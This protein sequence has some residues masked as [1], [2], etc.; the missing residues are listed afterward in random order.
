M[1][2]IYLF[3]KDIFFYILKEIIFWENDMKKGVIWKGDI[4]EFF[5][6]KI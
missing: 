1:F 2:Y 5:F 4:L 6:N 3:I